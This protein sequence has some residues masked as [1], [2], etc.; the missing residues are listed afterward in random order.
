MVFNVFG[1][2]DWS[3]RSQPFPVVPGWLRWFR[4]LVAAAGVLGSGCLLRWHP[5]RVLGPANRTGRGHIRRL[6]R[7]RGLGTTPGCLPSSAIVCPWGA[8]RFFDSGIPGG[9]ATQVGRIFGLRANEHRKKAGYRRAF[10]RSF[11]TKLSVALTFE[12][13][14]SNCDPRPDG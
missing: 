12:N 7:S 10:W 5:S 13:L 14:G 2:L 4:R 8:E 9:S 1:S 6:P 3:Q 11:G